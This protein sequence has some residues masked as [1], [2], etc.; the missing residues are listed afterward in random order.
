MKDK[1]VDFSAGK[2]KNEMTHPGF[3]PRTF[4]TEVRCPY[5]YTTNSLRKLVKKLWNSL[6]SGKKWQN[7]DKFKTL[8]A[9]RMHIFQA[10]SKK[11]FEFT[12]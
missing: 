8:K 6:F 11:T 9:P 1:N 10:A 7:Q 12:S 5:P 3:E 2:W 4:S